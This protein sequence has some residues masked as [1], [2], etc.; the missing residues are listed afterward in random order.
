M[1][2][3]SSPHSVVFCTQ[4]R[5]LAGLPAYRHCKITL[6]SA[7]EEDKIHNNKT[8][9]V[10]NIAPTRVNVTYP[11]SRHYSYTGSSQNRGVRGRTDPVSI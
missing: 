3:Q 8:P 9:R 1:S 6:S 11:V 10:V 7:D 2:T 4:I 5:Q